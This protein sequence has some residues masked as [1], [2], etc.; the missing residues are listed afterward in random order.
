MFFPPIKR[1]CT[2]PL[3]HALSEGTS[4][5]GEVTQIPMTQLRDVEIN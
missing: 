1:N 3:S 4:K 5:K 2:I